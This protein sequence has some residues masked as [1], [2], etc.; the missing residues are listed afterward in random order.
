MQL[1]TTFNFL[2]M[3]AQ[4]ALYQEVFTY[5]GSTNTGTQPKTRREYLNQ[6]SKVAF[7]VFNHKRSYEEMF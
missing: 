1:L 2:V 3:S 6:R 4:R 5:F 7:T